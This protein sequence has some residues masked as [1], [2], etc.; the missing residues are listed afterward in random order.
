MLL[1]THFRKILHAINHCSQQL[2]TDSI[3]LIAVETSYSI[4]K[5][6]LCL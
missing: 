4:M 1:V 6:V 2:G 5:M 3:K